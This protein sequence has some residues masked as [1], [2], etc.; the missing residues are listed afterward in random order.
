MQHAVRP[1]RWAFASILMNA[2]QFYDRNEI[3]KNRMQSTTWLQVI[4]ITELRA[5]HCN[6]I[7]SN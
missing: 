1:I 5:V 4:D 3:E 6:L 2:T 7:E